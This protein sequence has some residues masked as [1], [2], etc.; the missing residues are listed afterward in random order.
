MAAPS[1]RVL[2]LARAVRLR[3]VEN[4]LDPASH[5]ARR[6]GLYG[7]DRLENSQD[8]L[9]IDL[10]DGDIAEDRVGIGG[11]RALVFESM[12]FAAPPGLVRRDQRCR[13]ILEHDAA[14]FCE[15]GLSTSLAALLYG[16]STV[17]A[18]EA[19]LSGQL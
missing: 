7:P 1:R 11:K 6:L 12:F 8:E 3:P 19:G 15:L 17:A 2:S 18:A 16:I 14:S 4:R 5:A 13:R 10:A 9:G